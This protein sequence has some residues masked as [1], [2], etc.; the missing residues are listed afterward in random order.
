ME[1]TVPAIKAI[2]EGNSQEYAARITI[3]DESE[4]QS[5]VLS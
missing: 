1:N 4:Y 3:R 2:L 5:D